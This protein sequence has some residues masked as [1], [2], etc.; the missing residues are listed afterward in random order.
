[1]LARACFVGIRCS[2][3]RTSSTVGGPP[4]SFRRWAPRP[5][6]FP[7]NS[8]PL[9]ALDQDLITATRTWAR[10]EQALTTGPAAT[11]R[12]RDACEIAHRGDLVEACRDEHRADRVR[13]LVSVLDGEMPARH[14]VLWRARDQRPQ[15][16]EPVA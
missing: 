11:H 4:P 9:G 16:V 15:H 13:L 8:A 1:M 10:R 3:S 5:A 14:E 2:R 6:A 12:A 7:R